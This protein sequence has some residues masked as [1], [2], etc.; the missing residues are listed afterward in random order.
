MQTMIAGYELLDELGSGGFGRVYRARHSELGERAIKIAIDPAYARYLRQEGRA[1]GRLHH[2]RI[3]AIHHMDVD[4]DPPYLVMEYLPGGD[5]RHLLSQ[6]PLPVAR[7]AQIMCD[8]L[9]AL[10][11]AHSHGVIHRDIKPGN[12]LLD[13]EGRAKLS[14]FGLG[15]VVEETS[16]SWGRVESMRS[17]SGETTGTLRYMSP[18]QLDP[19]LLQDGPLDHRTDL[20]SLGLV[21]CEMLTGELPIGTA[22]EPPS[23]A[24]PGV[25]PEFDAIFRTL[26]QGRRERRYQDAQKTAAA[27]C[28]VWEVAEARREDSEPE[29]ARQR[30]IQEHDRAAME[31]LEQGRYPEA[32]AEWNRL[33]V[34]DPEHKSAKEGLA[35]ARR[36]Q[37]QM[38]DLAKEESRRGDRVVQYLR[39][40]K[41]YFEQGNH[42]AA[43]SAWQQVLALESRQTEALEGVDRAREEAHATADAVRRRR[44]NHAWIAVGLLCLVLVGMMLRQ[45]GRHSARV[46][47]PSGQGVEEEAEN[48]GPS[49]SGPP[50]DV[51]S[52]QTWVSPVD[53]KEMVYVPGGGERR[54]PPAA[55]VSGGVLDGPDGSDG[56]AIP[57]VLSGYR[58][59]D[60][61]GPV[62]GVGGG[63]PHREGHLERCGGV[64]GVGGEA[65]SDGCGVGEGGAGDGGEEVP[66]GRS[67]AGLP[68][69]QL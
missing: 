14:D 3:V 20:Y 27:L 33:L 32:L 28:V 46:A 5:L 57:K 60:A 47:P 53:G 59:S 18:E 50:R 6:G 48:S 36:Q 68:T 17:G 21:F 64:C 61:G 55:G 25:P 2:P 29:A 23:E 49:S 42:E 39:E 4:H 12:I 43:I 37:Q 30:A 24:R 54:T 26:T 44:A 8:V 13:E 66:L 34:P 22:P 56:S 67:A 15:R 63:A 1:V 10:E 58:Q 41:G 11:Y 16:R 7:A 40:A 35:E 45:G 65:A 9:E 51:A 62:L 31:L 69:L 52:G 38:D 19:G